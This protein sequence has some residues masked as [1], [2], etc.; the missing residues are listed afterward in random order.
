[1]IASARGLSPSSTASIAS[2]V[3]GTSRSRWVTSAGMTLRYA[4]RDPGEHRNLRGAPADHAVAHVDVEHERA[5]RILLDGERRDR[6][7]ERAL[8][9]GHDDL[10]G[11]E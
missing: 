3:I 10:V 9:V 6:P 7:D 11:P 2:S 8:V 5:E 1:M 4:D